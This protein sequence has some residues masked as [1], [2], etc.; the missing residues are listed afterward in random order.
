[1]SEFSFTKLFSSILKSTIWCEP[2]ATFKVFIFLLADADRHGRVM[3]TIP[4]IAN[5]TRVTLQECE[6]A[7]STFM[8]PDPYSRTPD[9]EGRR[10]EPIPGGWRLL[11]YDLYRD[12]R[13]PE[14]RREQLRTA[15]QRHRDRKRSVIN[16]DDTSSEA[17]TNGESKPKAEGRG[18]S[19]DQEQAASPS[20][21]PAAKVRE[22]RATRLPDD[23]TLSAAWAEW[24]REQR[25]DLNIAL[26]GAQFADHWRSRPGKDGRKRDWLAAWRYWVRSEHQ[27][28]AVA[29]PPEQQRY[30]PPDVTRAK[31]DAAKPRAVS[32]P[33]HAAAAFQ[34]ISSVL[35]CKQLQESPPCP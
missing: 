1:M 20:A 4:G 21:P 15:Q 26:V 6:Q 10:I 18:Q 33:E 32:S 25:P 14:A 24:A 22:E 8:S 17:T 2:H 29:L 3:G 16:S 13:D 11:N 9:H 31:R 28:R 34:E 12:K 35:R 23:W 5:A 30:D 19:E 27:P 7:L